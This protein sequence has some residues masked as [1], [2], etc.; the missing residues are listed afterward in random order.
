MKPIGE[1]RRIM[2]DG[3]ILQGSYGPAI[4]LTCQD[5]ACILNAGEE[6]ATVQITVYFTDKAPVGTY[7]LKVSENRTYYIHFNDLKGPEIPLNTD[8]SSVIISN[9]PVAVHHTRLDSWQ[10]INALISTIA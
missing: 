10:A 9:L 1:K 5:A 8:F 7:T 6:E 4:H 3:S 2:A